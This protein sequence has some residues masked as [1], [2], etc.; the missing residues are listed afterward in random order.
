MEY[1]LRGMGMD[2]GAEGDNYSTLK[3]SRAQGA[4]G[5]ERD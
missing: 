3:A 5:Q 2:V 1:R 4:P